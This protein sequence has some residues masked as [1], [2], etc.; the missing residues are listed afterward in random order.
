M[1]RDARDA[2]CGGVWPE[3][4]PD[5]LFG[6]DLALHL[7]GSIDRSENVSVRHAGPNRPGINRHFHPDWHRH[8]PHAPVLPEEIHDAPPA[9]ALLNMTHRQ[10]GHF[11]AA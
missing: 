1:R 5:H 4:L 11:G 8:S 9:I 7:V 3:H 10:R 2:G 6:Q